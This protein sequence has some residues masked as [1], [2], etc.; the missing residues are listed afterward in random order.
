LRRIA[1][2]LQKF[3]I[4]NPN[5]FII[6]I[7]QTGFAVDR[8]RPITAPLNTTVTK[9]EQCL[10]APTLI[11]YHGEQS[12]KET[13]GQSVEAPIMVV[14]AANRY[15]LVTSFLTKYYSGN[16]AKSSGADEPLHT[17]TAFDHNALVTSH[18]VKFKGD[19]YGH[20]ADEPLQTIT[21]SGYH[22]G[23]VR[24]F[25]TKYYGVTDGQKVTEPLHT[26]TTKD[27]LGL[28]MIHGQDYAIAD[29][30]LR[31]LTPR[32]LFNAQGFPIDYVIDVGADGRPL[33]KAAQVARC[34]NSV[35]PPLAEALVR[36]NLPEQCGAKLE[37]MRDLTL[38]MAV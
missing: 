9:A 11:Q 22:F 21:A 5:P 14:D 31:M 4:D 16:G 24:A 18:I 8:S 6:S 2:G 30:G 1:R 37:T 25:L 36:A 12:E 3:V 35:C 13:R 23:E 29:I 28:V 7:G 17:I 20:P 38:Q 15:G 26:V 19:N 10:V 32:E 27:R 33:T 34:G